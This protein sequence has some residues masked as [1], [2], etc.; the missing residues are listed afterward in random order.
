MN[1]TCNKIYYQRLP[2][3][4]NKSDLYLFV[5]LIRETIVS[6]PR[7]TKVSPGEFP[8]GWQQISQIS[9]VWTDANKPVY[10]KIF[11]KILRKKSRKLRKN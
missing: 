7:L 4:N 8:V 5:V 3:Y 2:F 6:R 10:K 9:P 1:K 11:G